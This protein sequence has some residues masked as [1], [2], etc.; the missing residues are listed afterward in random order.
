MRK[1][2]VLG[3][4]MAAGAA[5]AAPSVSATQPTFA[6][7]PNTN[8]TDTTSCPFPVSVQFIVNDETAITFTSGT[9]IVKGPLFAKYSANGKSITLN[10]S[11][12]G[13]ITASNGSLLIIGHGVSAGPLVTPNGL[14]LSYV[15]GQVAISLTPTLEGVLLHGTDLLDICTALA[16]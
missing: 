13:K 11:G 12:P 3:V 2:L 4:L 9:T 14:V 1:L 7:S 6:P 15:A 5:I 16:P 8:Y 10:I